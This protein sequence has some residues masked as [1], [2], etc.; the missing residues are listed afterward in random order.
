[1]SMIQ[2]FFGAII[3]SFERSR[4]VDTVASTREMLTNETL[5]MYVECVEFKG[6]P[7]AQPF[8][9][10]QMKNFNKIFMREVNQRMNF[11]EGTAQVFTN[12][13]NDF[14]GAVRSG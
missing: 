8:K 2:E 10:N 4:L 5:P 14:R 9:S 13:T 3:P 7:G 6:F 12:L 11:I 1:M